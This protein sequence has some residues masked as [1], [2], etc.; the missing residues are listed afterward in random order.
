M[1]WTQDVFGNLVATAL[2]EE[3]SDTLTIDSRVIVD[4]R[5]TAWPIFKIAPSAHHFP[6]A[7]A[8][9]EVADLGR[10]RAPQYPAAADSVRTWLA[11]FRCEEPTDTLSLLKAINAGI[12]SQF[13][14]QAREAEGTQAPEDTIR[15]GTGSCRDLA[16]LFL[17]AVRLLGFGA[18]AVSG[19][20]YDGDQPGAGQHG[21]TH[22]WAE[23]YLP[24][25][26]WIAFDPTNARMGGAD[27][28]PIAVARTIEQ[29]PPVTGSYTGAPGDFLGMVIEVDVTPGSL[30]ARLDPDAERKA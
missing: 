15:R 4:Q 23:V 29:I 17:E 22:A 26:G 19:Y 12:A 21:S 1:E 6:F 28:V 7:Y 13:A 20:L 2:F 3:P 9:D 30:P 18:R 8:P 5:A 27:L 25:A 10:L 11:G 24:C 14:Y 16:A